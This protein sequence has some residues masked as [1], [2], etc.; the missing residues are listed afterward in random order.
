MINAKTQEHGTNGT[1]QHTL[2]RKHAA[3]PT[4]QSTNDATILQCRKYKKPIPDETG[5]QLK[6]DIEEP[7]QH[8]EKLTQA[9]QEQQW[10]QERKENHPLTK[11]DWGEWADYQKTLG[12]L[13]VKTYQL[14][15]QETTS[16]EPAWTLRLEEWGTQ[17][18]VDK[19]EHAYKKEIA[20]NKK[21]PK[22]RERERE[23]ERKK[24]RTTKKTETPTET[25]DN[26]SMGGRSKMPTGAQERS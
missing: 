9:Y 10:K 20:Y 11:H 2:A 17:Q 24:E 4:T 14:K 23:R 7:R 22:E 5:E 18:E 25:R 12:E 3:K 15:K 8:P 13:L 6:Y 16:K 1:E 26:T 21:S 19:F